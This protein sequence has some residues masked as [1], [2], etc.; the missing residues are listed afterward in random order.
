V[1]GAPVQGGWTAGQ[2][3]ASGRLARDWVRNWAEFSAK[4]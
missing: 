2:L 4:R 1:P 3:T